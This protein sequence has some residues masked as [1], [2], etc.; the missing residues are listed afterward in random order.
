MRECLSPHQFICIFQALCGFYMQ[1]MILRLPTRRKHL[2]KSA[3]QQFARLF[4]FPGV[5]H[6]GN[7]YGP[8]H[9]DLVTTITNWVE[10][11]TAPSKI[12]T[13]RY[14]SDSSQPSQGGPPPSNTSSTKPPAGQVQPT[15]GNATQTTGTV[16]RT[17]P[18]FPY[19]Q[20]P[21]YSGS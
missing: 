2:Q 12:I 1:N 11:G 15:G 9:F 14:S 17:L 4:M 3:T 5:Y 21:K 16:V 10:H 20:V 7:G 8:Y 6:C 13:T 19:P 18:I